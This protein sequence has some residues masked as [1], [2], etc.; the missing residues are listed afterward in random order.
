MM[1]RGGGGGGGGAV[2]YVM[3]VDSAGVTSR[4]YSASPEPRTWCSQWGRT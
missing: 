2:H 1:R 3:L 4:T